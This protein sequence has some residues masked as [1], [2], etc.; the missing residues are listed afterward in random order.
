MRRGLSLAEYL[1]HQCAGPTG[2]RRL[3]VAVGRDAFSAALC[4][5]LQQVVMMM[6]MIDDGLLRLLTCCHAH[7]VCVGI[8][9][10]VLYNFIYTIIVVI[11]CKQ[12][13]RILTSHDLV[14]P[15]TIL[16]P[17][18]N[19]IIQSLCLC[20]C[21]YSVL[22]F[23]E[24][25]SEGMEWEIVD[26]LTLVYGTLVLGETRS[27]DGAII[28]HGNTYSSS[29][30]GGEK[31][32]S[33]GAKTSGGGRTG[34]LKQSNNNNNNNSQKGFGSMTS[35][36]DGSGGGGGNGGGKGNNRNGGSSSASSMNGG[37][38]GDGSNICIYSDLPRQVLLMLPQTIHHSSTS[39][40]TSIAPLVEHFERQLSTQLS[41]KKRR[42]YLKDF[43]KAA[44]T[45]SD[46]SNGGSATKGTRSVLDIRK[47]MTV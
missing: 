12:H 34:G 6:R 42:E 45:G 39:I 36:Q 29:V 25:W 32:V 2:D 27:P 24:T 33:G 46:S 37:G 17:H 41:K 30:G 11:R 44:A 7:C 22:L 13:Y 43:L 19:T 3:V 40:V 20:L 9:L 8:R 16:H 31:Y 38:G 10:L 5:L 15:S 21:L 28:P 23:Q 1:I 18:R 35:W 14:S 26:F 4:V 47:R